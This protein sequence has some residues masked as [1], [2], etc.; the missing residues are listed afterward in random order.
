M[1]LPSHN[2]SL[3]GDRAG[4]QPGTEEEIIERSAY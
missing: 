3:R 2:T 4:A 1:A